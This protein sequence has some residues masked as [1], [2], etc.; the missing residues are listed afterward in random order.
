MLIAL[1][2]VAILALTILALP[3]RIVRQTPWL[4]AALKP[5]APLFGMVI[6]ALSAEG[7]T[8]I[9]DANYIERGYEDIIGKLTRL[10]AHIRRIETYETSPEESV[11]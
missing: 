1:L 8:T 4:A 5:F 9:E 11:G 3:S 6:A 7:E 10:G 2:V